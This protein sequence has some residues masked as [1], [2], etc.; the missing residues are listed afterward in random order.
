MLLFDN[1]LE[2]SKKDTPFS[3]YRIFLNIGYVKTCKA[4][5]LFSI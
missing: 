5:N 3:I 2:D 4:V 1:G